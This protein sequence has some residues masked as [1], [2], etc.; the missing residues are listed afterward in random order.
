M[1]NQKAYEI[2]ISSISSAVFIDEKA[3]N[4]F[5]DTP[6]NTEIVEEKLS[7]SLFNTFKE[8]GKS[9]T[10]HKFEKEN[11]DNP[12][13]INY[14][15]NGRDLILLDWELD[16]LSGQEYSLKLLSKA[17]ELP[18]INF[19]CIYSR[20]TNFNDIPNYL[21]AYFSGLNIEDIK[22]IEQTYEYIE[23][24]DILEFRKNPENS[25]EEFFKENKIT[26]DAFPIERFKVNSP[27]VILDLIYIV[28]ENKKY[29]F[30][31]EAFT[32]YEVIYSTEDSFVI[33]NTFV[34][35][36]KKEEENDSDYKNLIKRISDVVVKNKSSFFQ[37]LGLEM[38]Y[39]FNNNEKFIDESILKSSTEA[40]FS[41]RNHLKDDKIFGIIIK[42]LLI[43]QAALKLRTAKLKL[44]DSE[45]L[46]FHGEK[47]KDNEITTNDLLQLNVFYNSVSIKSLNELDLPNLNFGDIFKDE[48][49]NYYLCITA[50][51][52]CYYPNKIDY[53]Y[54]F[55]KGKEFDNVEIAL[56]LGDTAFISFLPNNK[57][58]YWGDI[59]HPKREKISKLKDESADHFKIRKLEMDLEACKY[60]LY[61]PFYVKPKVYNVEN[62]KLVE[63]TIRIWDITNKKTKL[64]TENDI[65]YL[66][67]QYVT[68][69]R[70]DY[71]QR[72]ANHAFGHSTRVGVD[73]VKK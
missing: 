42:K 6:I 33:N 29:I 3:K 65:N 60:F 56:K 34:L 26:Y 32:N 47:L 24:K 45:F 36:I 38:Q 19:C 5:S 49:S 23:V 46:N 48:A 41:F 13:L 43:E 40:F 66:N 4:F 16:D 59:E 30:Q 17:I 27:K 54:Y 31:S 8:N 35:V 20:S 25:I 37:L 62:N 58:V 51:C 7:L 28:L 9:L 12:Q 73:F 21:T 69:L 67:V 55:V 61:K 50:L 64:G 63:N 39:I 14:L 70:N 72:I 10:V 18:Y 53:N 71:T 44:L 52:D 57:A 1:Y 22:L 2:L 68:T 11:I 15:F